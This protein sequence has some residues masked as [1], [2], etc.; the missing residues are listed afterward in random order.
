[1]VAKKTEERKAR[2]SW[3]GMLRF[4]LVAFPVEAI[5]A[6]NPDAARVS[7]NQ[8]HADCH[9]RI[10]Y[11]KVCPVHGPVKQSEIVSGYEYGRGRYVEIDPEELNELRSE[12]ERALSIDSFVSPDAI[13]PIQLDGRMYYLAPDG[14]AAREPYE[15]FL[16]ALER[17]GVYG[18]GRIVFSGKDQIVLVRP[19]QG[20]L[21]L[22]MLSYAAEI[23]KPEATVGELP[24]LPRGDKKVRLAE[25]L[26]ESWKEE[27]FDFSDYVDPYD[28]KVRELI[29]AKVEGREI[30][31]PEEE[32][33]ETEVVNLMEALRA[34]MAKS[35]RSRGPAPGRRAASAS[36]RTGRKR[37]KAS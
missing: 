24:R 32:P 8:L 6:H 14:D 11:E 3:S 34:S 27:K 21:L 7:F 36:P 2:A 35:G 37:R 15:V 22:S 13:D 28:K 29:E 1:M 33:E 9:S 10:R 18:V 20:V 30:V 19:Y 12:Q 5:N 26:I 23:R 17:Q 4:G 16:E 31:T 25:Q